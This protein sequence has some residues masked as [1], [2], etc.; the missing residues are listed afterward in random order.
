MNDKI[1]NINFNVWAN[2]EEEAFEL[3]KALGEF[4]DWFGQRG[5]KVSADKLTTAINNWQNNILV[6][7][8]IINHFNKK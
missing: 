8:S 3:R 5:I 7:N 6:K 4:V 2:N 1:V